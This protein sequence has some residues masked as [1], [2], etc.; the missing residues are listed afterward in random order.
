MGTQGSFCVVRQF[1]SFDQSTYA[2]REVLGKAEALQQTQDDLITGDGQNCPRRLVA[3]LCLLQ[4][5]YRKVCR[6][7]GI[8]TTGHRL[9]SLAMGCRNT[10]MLIFSGIS[11]ICL[12]IG[13]SIEESGWM[14]AVCPHSF[15]GYC[16]YW[17]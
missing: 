12:A 10:G 15:D 6:G 9:F 5:R 8:P 7:C 11:G 16:R 13:G 2:I 3:A 14:I 4:R 17:R 1:L